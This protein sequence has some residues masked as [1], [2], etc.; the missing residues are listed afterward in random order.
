M[1][2]V[3]H[4]LV[5][6]AVPLLLGQEESFFVVEE[7]VDPGAADEDY[8]SGLGTVCPSE[9]TR[10]FID[11]DTDAAKGRC[12]KALFAPKLLDKALAV[13]GFFDAVLGVAFFA[14]AADDVFALVGKFEPSAR[15]P[16]P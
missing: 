5:T 3:S 6:E 11:R 2:G 13:E 15:Q 14:D 9:G 1:G 10:V 4:H 16:C 7:V 12:G 8:F